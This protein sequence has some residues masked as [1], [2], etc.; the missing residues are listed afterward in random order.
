MEIDAKKTV[1]VNAKKLTISCKVA[2][3][4]AAELYDQD[5]EL[6]KDH[7]GYVP[8][9][10]PGNHYGDYVMLDIDIDTGQITNWKVPTRRQIE[11]FIEGDE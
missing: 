3:T 5:G 4:F 2:D 7:E 11:E 8:D 6:L 9:F 10:M 1:R